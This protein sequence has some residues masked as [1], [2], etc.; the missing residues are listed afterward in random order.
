MTTANFQ[1][2]DYVMWFTRYGCT[3]TRVM[4]SLEDCYDLAWM[5]EDAEACVFGQYGCF[6]AVEKV[7]EGVIPNDVWDAGLEAYQKRVTAR[8][9]AKREENPAPKPAGAIYVYSPNKHERRFGSAHFA[10]AYSVEDFNEK[11]DRATELFGADRV[12]FRWYYLDN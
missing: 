1:P 2:G 6:C 5:L 10:N 11:R 4:D 7:G 9:E 3:E 12:D 8:R